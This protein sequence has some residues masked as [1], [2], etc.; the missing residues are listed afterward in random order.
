MKWRSLHYVLR[1]FIISIGL[2]LIFPAL[3]WIFFTIGF[4]K[5][6]VILKQLGLLISYGGAGVLLV[7]G[8]GTIEIVSLGSI[9]NVSQSTEIIV[10]F[11]T[12]WLI[13]FAIVLTCTKIAQRKHDS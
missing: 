6:I 5:N 2:V 7:L 10:G 13:F 1:S 8:E 3:G 9:T 4:G 11:L 12:V